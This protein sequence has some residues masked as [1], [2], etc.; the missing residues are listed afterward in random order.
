MINNV[1][2][3]HNFMV[4]EI[5]SFNASDILFCF[6]ISRKEAYE[7]YRLVAASVYALSA[8]Y[9]SR[10][11]RLQNVW[12]KSTKKLDDCATQIGA[13]RRIESLKKRKQF[14]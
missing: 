6:A 2:Y 5:E 13:R 12:V 10:G 1:K 8:R 14:I 9:T 7:G 11:N 4:L 3:Y